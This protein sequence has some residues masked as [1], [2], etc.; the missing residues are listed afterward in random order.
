MPTK[1]KKSIKNPLLP[2]LVLGGSV[3][4][5]AIVAII[6][7]LVSPKPEPKPVPSVPTQITEPAT[8]AT[9]PVPL[10]SNPL[11]PGDFSKPGAFVSCL[12]QDYA[13]GIDVSEWQTEIDWTEVANTVD[14]E[15]RRIEFVMIRA[16]RR[17]EEQGGLYEDTMA[18]KHYAGAKAAG[19]KVGAYFFSQA[20]SPQEAVEEAN[21]LLE[22]TRDWQLDMPVVFNWEHRA[23]QYRTAVVDAPLLTQC[24]RAF[25]DTVSQAGHTP[26]VYFNV[27]DSFGRL[28]LQELTA[29]Q[30]WLAQYDGFL[31]YPYRVEMWQYTE[32]GKV[33]GIDGNVD[34]NLYFKW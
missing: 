26:M 19:L 31:D 20:I 28:Q 1:R 34:I 9:K 12:T 7:F 3:L 23:D 2:E 32:T 24:V 13:L 16:G 8:Q 30:F 6:V 10:T 21:F 33:P 4:V 14:T 17:G 5:I 29:Y 18:R 25:C 15:G 27:A 11:K 22:I